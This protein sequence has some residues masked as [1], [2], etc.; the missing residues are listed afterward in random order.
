[1]LDFLTTWRTYDKLKEADGSLRP[2]QASWVF[3]HVRKGLLTYKGQPALGEKW[4]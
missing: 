1:M 2:L 4:R 3:Q